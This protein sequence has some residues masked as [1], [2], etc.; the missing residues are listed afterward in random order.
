MQPHGRPRGRA[1]PPNRVPPPHVTD[2]T[3]RKARK[4][5][6]TD[7]R[8]RFAR[9]LGMEGQTVLFQTSESG[10]VEDAYG[11]MTCCFCDRDVSDLRCVR[12]FDG[13]L[14]CFSPACHGA[15]RASR[16]AA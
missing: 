7:E 5:L 6:T 2:G 14:R 11:G 1:R 4:R 13:R 16:G 10:R 3:R 12:T 15:E 8:E 9:I